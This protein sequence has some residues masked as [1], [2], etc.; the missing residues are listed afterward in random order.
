MSNPTDPIPTSKQNKAADAVTDAVREQADV[1]REQA[2]QTTKGAQKIFD[3]YVDASVSS[4]RRSQELAEKSY[5]AWTES[6]QGGAGSPG[7]RLP[8]PD[9]H[10]VVSVG[11][12]FA[13]SVLDAQREIA[14]QLVDAFAP[15]RS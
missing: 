5:K 14:N 10:E 9:L 1:L 4:F 13:Q 8:T 3:T 2:E 7:F 11:F 12:D 15:A 6:W